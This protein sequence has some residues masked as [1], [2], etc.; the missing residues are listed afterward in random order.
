MGTFPNQPNKSPFISNTSPTVLQVLIPN[1]SKSQRE[2][3]WLEALVDF[4]AQGY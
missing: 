2:D 1:A 3:G 4:L